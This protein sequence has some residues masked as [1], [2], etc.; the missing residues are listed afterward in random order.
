MPAVIVRRSGRQTGCV[1]DARIAREFHATYQKEVDRTMY[2]PV[3]MPEGWEQLGSGSYRAAYRAPSGVVYKVNH[4][5]HDGVRTKGN[6]YAEMMN[7]IR[8][9]KTGAIP[10]GWAVPD[11]TLYRVTPTL[12]RKHDYVIAMPLVDTSTP[13]SDCHWQC[14]CKSEPGNARVGGQCTNSIV[15]SAEHVFKDLHYGNAFP[16]KNGVMIVLDVGL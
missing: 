15:A 6:N 7:I 5:L 16:S 13:L 8:L 12:S 14:T 3:C 11:A 1:R 4:K 9:R 2:G 10:K